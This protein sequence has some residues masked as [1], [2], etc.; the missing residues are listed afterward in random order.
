MSSGIGYAILLLVVLMALIAGQATGA[1]RKM[2]R[3]S[4][5][6]DGPHPLKNLQPLAAYD[7]DESGVFRRTRW[8]AGGMFGLWMLVF[9]FFVPPP[10]FQQPLIIRVTACAAAG[11]CFGV[12]MAASI[13]GRARSAAEG[14]YTGKP[15]FIAP[16]PADRQFRYQLPCSWATAQIA[17]F[18]VLYLGREGLLLVAY[19]L[20]RRN[21]PPVEIGP[22]DAI[23]WKLVDPA[24]RS[25]W[26]RFRVPHPSKWIEIS[27]GESRAHLGVPRPADTLERFRAALADL[28][29]NS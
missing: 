28:Q 16:P 3:Q 22:P 7:C 19:R 14:V 8:F 1:R 6:T 12:F 5:M 29:A 2:N 24:K 23:R 9:S 26:Q 21:P 15:N 27:W 25:A 10:P 11:L 17:S 20:D 13:R 18:G 4:V